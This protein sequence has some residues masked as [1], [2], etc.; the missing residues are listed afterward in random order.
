MLPRVAAD[1]ILEVRTW[2]YSNPHS[3]L[4]NGQCCVPQNNLITTPPNCQPSACNNRFHYCLRELGSSVAECSGGRMSQIYYAQDNI[5][6]KS[7]TALG[8]PNPLPLAGLTREWRVSIN[9]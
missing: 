1:Y 8:L 5:N 9:C 2:S 3:E 7:P 4:A 6:F